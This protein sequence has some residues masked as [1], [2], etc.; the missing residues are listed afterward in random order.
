VINADFVWKK[1]M[2][3][4]EVVFIIAKIVGVPRVKLVASQLFWKKIKYPLLVSVMKP[5]RA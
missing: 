3:A 5:Y 1:T 2:S 4:A